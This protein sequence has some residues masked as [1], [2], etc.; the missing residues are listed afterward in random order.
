MPCPSPWRRLQIQLACLLVVG[1]LAAAWSIPAQG[2]PG[3]APDKRKKAESNMESPPRPDAGADAIELA[4]LTAAELWLLAQAEAGPAGGGRGAA[5]EAARGDNATDAVQLMARAFAPFVERKEIKVRQDDRWLYVE[6]NG[7]PNHPLMIGIKAWQ[8]Q[9]PLPQNYTGANAWQIPLHPVPAKNPRSARNDFLRGAIAVAINGIPIFNPLTN[10]GADAWLGGELDE[11]GGHCGRA[12]DYHYHL[13][14]VHLQEL[15]GTSQPIA[16]A[17]DGYPIY[18]YTEPDGSPVKNLD[19]L[20]GHT[21]AEGRYHYHATKK[22][23][24]ING[25]FHG[26]VVSREGQVEPQSRAEPVRPDL[27]PLKGARIVGFERESETRS[28]LTYEVD[29]KRHQVRYT[30]QSG[31]A[32]AFQFIDPSGRVVEETY[33]PRRR[34]DDRGGRGGQG[35]RDDNPGRGEGP[36]PRRGG[37]RPPRPG[38]DNP[39]PERRRGAPRGEEPGDP[40]PPRPRDDSDPPERGRPGPDR[41]DNPP[42]GKGRGDRERGRPPEDRPAPPKHKSVGNLKLSSGSVDQRGVLSIDCSCDGKA[43]SPAVEWT[44]VPAGTE[45]LAISL[46]HV[47]PDQEKSYWVLYNIPAASTGVAAAVKQVGTVGTNGKR[48]VGYDPLC[49]Q[50]PGQKTYHIT[51]FALSKKLNLTPAQATREGLLKAAAGSILAEQTLDVIY[52]R[53]RSR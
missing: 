12:D 4:R 15:L 32:V 39:P 17:L 47:A 49:S 38:D 23:P 33:Q 50:G 41:D 45:S 44:G 51:V 18:G 14:P 10:R 13:A 36:P 6:S 7:L 5:G 30:V 25:G 46:W 11:W 21:D 1:G 22:Y 29:G 26:E 40:P 27:R 31:G 8:Q 53:P 43:E 34:R 20:N 24:Y 42:P 35:N 3:H 48:R 37:D 2:H 16:Y 19:A 52:E 9:V 28:K